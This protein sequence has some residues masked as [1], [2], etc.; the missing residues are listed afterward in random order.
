MELLIEKVDPD[1]K[2]ILRNLMTLHLHD[3]SE[4]INNIELN[5]DKGL[6][7][8][9]ILDWFFEKDGLSPFFIHL[10]GKPIGFILLQ[11]GPFSNQEYADYVLNSFFILRN[12]RRKGFGRL[13][14]QKFFEMYP[15]RYAIGQAE[16]NIPA[17]KFWRKVYESSGINTYEKEEIEEGIKIVY[18]YFKTF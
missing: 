18:Q 5:P 15:G 4:F 8:F 3:L 10:E 9:D 2:E 12:H 14:C 17:L 1:K 13:A 11:S 16:T 7:E 6:F